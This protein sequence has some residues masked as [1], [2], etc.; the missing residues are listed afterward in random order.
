MWIAQQ[1]ALNSM[2]SAAD[3]PDH[4][5]LCLW[6]LLANKR[7]CTCCTELIIQWHTPQEIY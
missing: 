2:H 1:I 7:N 5:F 6:Q 4:K 3:I